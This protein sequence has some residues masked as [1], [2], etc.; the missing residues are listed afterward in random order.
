MI[1][2]MIIKAFVLF[3]EKTASQIIT[4]QSITTAY[5]IVCSFV[6]VTNC[7]F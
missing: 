6:V 4:Q 3:F 2:T 1:I 5:F 7:S